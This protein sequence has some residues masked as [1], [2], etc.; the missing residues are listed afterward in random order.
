MSTAL[1]IVLALL[2]I[3]GVLWIVWPKHFRV[4]I[5]E[6]PE[7][8]LRIVGVIEIILVVIVVLLA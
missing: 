4:I 7:I 3:E 8:M 5:A 1:A 2:A 6:T